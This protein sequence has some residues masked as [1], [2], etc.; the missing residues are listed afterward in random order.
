MF[1]YCTSLSSL[2]DISKWN[3]CKVK[4][5]YEIFYNSSNFIYSKKIKSKFNIK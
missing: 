1:S 5:I 4:D 2:P 3:E